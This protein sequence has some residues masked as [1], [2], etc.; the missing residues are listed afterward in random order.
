MM[1]IEILKKMFKDNPGKATLTFKGKCSV[2]GIEVLIEVIPTS[3]GF[4]LQGGALFQ[5]APNVYIAKCSNCY[6]TNLRIRD[7]SKPKYNCMIV[8]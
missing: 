3:G 7:H 5:Y 8:K 6:K 4:G 1:D 2:C